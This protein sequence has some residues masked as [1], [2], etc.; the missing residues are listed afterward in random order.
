[1]NVELV[2]RRE[3]LPGLAQKWDELAR[4]DPRDGFF[5]SSAWYMAW[6]DHVRTDAQPF[7]VVVRDQSGEIVGLAPLCRAPYRDLGF[8]LTGVSTGGREMVS[9][10]FLDYPSAPHVREEVLQTILSFLWERRSEWEMLV[11]GE[12]TVGGDLHRAIESFAEVRGL[13]FRLQEERTCPFIELPPTFEQYLRGLSQK[14][15]YEMRRDTRDL[16]EKM[17][18]RIE[19]VTEPQEVC[20]RLDTV[21]QLHVAHWHNVNLPGTLSRPEMRGFLKQF[22]AAPP[23]GGQTRLYFL[24]HEDTPAAAVFTFW[25]GENALFYQTGWDPQSPAA[26]FSPGM[27]LV[28]WSIRDAIEGGMKYYDFLRGDEAYKVRLTKS[29]RKTATLLLA[30]SFLAKEYLRANRLKDSM[31]RMMGDESQAAG[32]PQPAHGRI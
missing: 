17:G 12:V 7:I 1:M 18:T 23:P 27:V 21:I 3:D 14:M 28:G 32:T 22:C 15:R 30:R 9:G 13:G 11:T 31:K 8:R 10:D 26:R 5:R 19:V 24:K 20:D 2:T 16:L 25:Y 29:S 4:N 6:M